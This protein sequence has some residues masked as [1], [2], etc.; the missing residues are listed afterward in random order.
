MSKPTYNFQHQLKIGEEGENYLDA[1]LIRHF[2][3][4]RANDCQQK[5]MGIDRILISKNGN[6]FA[7][8][9]KTDLKAFSTGNYFIETHSSVGYNTA[10]WAY[11]SLAQ[12][13]AFYIPQLGRAWLCNMVDIKKRLHVWEIDCNTGKAQNEG[14]TTQGLLVPREKIE[15]LAILN[16]EHLPKWGD[17]G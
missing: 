7:A 8:E 3:I 2:K 11:K 5:D 1:E 4:E 9:Y 13:I 12:L 15:S 16:L 10:G 17:N 14:Y 6:R